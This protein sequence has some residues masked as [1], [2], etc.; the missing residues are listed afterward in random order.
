MEETR[1]PDLRKG[2]RRL[3]RGLLAYGIV[4]LVVATIGFGALAWVN[5]RVGNARVE[6]ETTVGQL[7]TTMER[8]ARL[9]HDGSATARSFSVTLGRSAEGLPA[10][11]GQ[12]AGLRSDLTALE[13]QLRSVSILG[14]TPLSSAAD[15]VGRIAVSLE[16]LDTQIS[17]I[18]VVLTANGDALA[19]NATSLAQLGDSTAALAARLRSGVIEG[20][21]G[22]V[23]T[24]IV[25]MLLVST[26]W[27]VVPA[28]GALALGVWLRRVLGS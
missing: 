12:I 9:L 20:S 4:G 17:V 3:S 16:G 6:A 1:L 11:S 2:L 22:D 5:G 25:V 13:G 26:A 21:I 27:A 18:A 19:A 15:A 7:A 8:T 23:Q 14:A 28:V 10:A 24:V